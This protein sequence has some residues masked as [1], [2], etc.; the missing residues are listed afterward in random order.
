MAAMAFSRSAALSA[1][2]SLIAGL[3][4]GA[5]TVSVAVI[6]WSFLGTCPESPDPV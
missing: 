6:S 2:A 1:G 5:V 3:V 4:A